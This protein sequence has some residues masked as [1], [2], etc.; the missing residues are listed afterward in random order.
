MFTRTFER[1]A[2]RLVHGDLALSGYFSSFDQL[3]RTTVPYEVAAWATHDPA[4][5]LTTS[6]TLSG[7]PPDAQREA[8]IFRFEFRDDEP[9][10]YLALIARGTTVSVLS[11]ETDGDLTKAGRYREVF[12]PFGMTDELRAILRADGQVWG[13]LSLYRLG[14][15]F[16]A[17]EADRIAALAPVIADGL[18]LVMLRA[19]AARPHA[20]ED[21][22]GVLE[23]DNRGHVV[24][25]TVPARR[26][27]D[28]GGEPLRTAARVAASALRER[29]DWAG[30][31]SRVVA[32]DDRILTL[33]A[34]HATV[35]DGTVAVIVEAARPAEV[36]SVLVAAYGLT[37]RQRDVLGLLLLGRSM[38]Q[39][40]R[41]LGIS[42]HT[43][44][45]HRKAIYRRFGVASRGELAA[46]LP[47]ESYDPLISRGAIPSPYGGFLPEPS[48]RT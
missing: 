31:S 45:D 7:I 28:V 43:A 46:L 1:D 2:G 15:T 9:A 13:S 4:T 34:A 17:E 39:I 19:A 3:L 23:V 24:A 35:A 36:A 16:D 12:R 21:P 8:D 33:H 20:V 29:A 10:T 37:E 11:D 48:P 5:G 22:P 47:S 14:T 42:E 32:R 40:A 25:A 27:L 30:T 41:H 38:V 18:R 44:N 26:W 6:C